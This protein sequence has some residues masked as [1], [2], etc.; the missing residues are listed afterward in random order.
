MRARSSSFKLFGYGLPSSKGTF[1]LLSNCSAMA[2]H[3]SGV[4]G[5]VMTSF[6]YSAAKCRKVIAIFI[7]S[8]MAF[9]KLVSLLVHLGPILVIS[10]SNISGDIR[11]K[12]MKDAGSSCLSSGIRRLNWPNWRL[13]PTFS[14]GLT[15]HLL[16]LAFLLWLLFWN[17]SIIFSSASF[18]LHCI[19]K[20]CW[21]RIKLLMLMLK[22]DIVTC[23]W[24]VML[25]WCVIL[26][27]TWHETWLFIPF[28]CELV[29]RT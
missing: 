5:H 18:S 29:C 2:F 23:Q 12:L 24:R 8:S 22:W 17:I 19:C 13:L 25:S 6:L 1:H 7:S 14:Q 15:Q 10:S 26:R 28:V 9:L 20:S 27:S 11:R 3:S 21:R 4:L 16:G